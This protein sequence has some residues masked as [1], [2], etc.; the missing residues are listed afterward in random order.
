MAR[1][2]EGERTR[3]K[4]EVSL[5]RLAVRLAESQ[6]IRLVVHGAGRIG[7]CPFDD[8]REPSLV[9]TP[10]KW[11][12]WQGWRYRGGA[13]SERAPRFAR[14][15]GANW[16]SNGRQKNRVARLRKSAKSRRSPPGKGVGR[17]GLE[18][19]MAL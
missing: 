5:E 8:D 14:G 19:R 18:P 10:A 3:L 9:I 1:I 12:D 6:G 17:Q 11:W 16:A 7:L 2:P 4:A 13:P 15:T